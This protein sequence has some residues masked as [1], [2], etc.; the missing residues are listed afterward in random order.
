MR[1]VADQGVR[2]Q[3]VH[4]QGDRSQRLEIEV[5]GANRIAAAPVLSTSG[6]HC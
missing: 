1:I 4:R 3:P 6:G 2:L 5:D